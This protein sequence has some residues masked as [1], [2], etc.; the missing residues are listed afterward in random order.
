MDEW[1]QHAPHEGT[2][3]G[4]RGPVVIGLPATPACDDRVRAPIYLLVGTISITG[5][6]PKGRGAAVSHIREFLGANLDR[7]RVLSQRREGFNTLLRFQT[8][9]ERQHEDW[10]L[11]GI[12]AACRNASAGHTDVLARVV[13]LR[14]K[15]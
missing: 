11:E 4:D 10:V 13:T 3:G 6:N 7:S 1:F 14:T 15:R 9:T 2:V 8:V 12:G 5:S